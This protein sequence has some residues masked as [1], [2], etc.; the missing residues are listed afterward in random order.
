MIKIKLILP[1]LC[2]IYAGIV[3]SQSG[4]DRVPDKYEDAAYLSQSIPGTMA[5]GETYG[6]SVTMKNTGQ[7]T[8][9]RGNY[10]LKLTNMIEAT[11]KTWSISSVDVNSTVS[12]GNEVIFNFNIVA[13]AEGNYT[14][15]WQMANGNAFFGEPTPIIP[16]R[17]TGPNT[18]VQPDPISNNALFVS[19]QVPGTMET[20]QAYDVVITM[21]NSGSTTWTPGDYKLKISTVGAD[22]TKNA[23]TIP[24]VELPFEIKPGTDVT[25]RFKITA[26][27][28]SGAYNFQAQLVKD[29]ILFG[30]P[31]TNVIFTVD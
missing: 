28:K 14:M 24:N 18:K 8:W 1:A 4:G 19:Q 25:F 30:Q 29:E 3:Y 11:A 31:T 27:Q 2:L 21:R 23:W 26:P 15:Q 17:V 13:P 22:N 9:S 20:N 7:S 16:I 5:P 12:S 6:V 10:S